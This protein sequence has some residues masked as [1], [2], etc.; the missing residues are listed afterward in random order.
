MNLRPE[1]PIQNNNS[2]LY[3]FPRS[4]IDTYWKRI[5]R[6][7]SRAVELYLVVKD[8]CHPPTK[9]LATKYPITHQYLPLMYPPYKGTYFAPSPKESIFGLIV[10]LCWAI[11]EDLDQHVNMI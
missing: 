3:S 8:N 4:S 9:D 7:N 10:I 6:W 2:T 1:A 5:Q 11:I